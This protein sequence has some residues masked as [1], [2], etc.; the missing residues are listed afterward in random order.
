MW[1]ILVQIVRVVQVSIIGKMVQFTKEISAKISGRAKEK[2]F[3]KMA[4][5]IGDNGKMA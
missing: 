5:C 3:G 1:E 2:W 4:V